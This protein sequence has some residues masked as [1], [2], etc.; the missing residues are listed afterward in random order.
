M[1]T[2]AVAQIVSPTAAPTDRPSPTATLSPA[3]T[4]SP[5]LPTTAPTE[6]ADSE[7]GLTPRD[8]VPVAIIAQLVIV[9]VAGFAYFRRSGS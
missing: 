4:D 9:G 6:A 3:P 2:L 7:D 8:L 5:P 1:K